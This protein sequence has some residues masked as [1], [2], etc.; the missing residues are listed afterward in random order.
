M[1]K[2]QIISILIFVLL[3]TISGYAGTQK[4]K[5]VSMPK[6][7]VEHTPRIVSAFA[8]INS[9]PQIVMTVP[10]G[11]KF[12]LTDIVSSNVDT[13][14][15]LEDEEIKT[16]VNL[17]HDSGYSIHFKSGIPFSSNS[18]IVIFINNTNRAITISGYLLKN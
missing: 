16:K 5:I 10:D 3:F 1:K 2:I 11:R 7:R 12:I 13:Y 6:V 14:D 9:E 4:M 17:N 8:I 15:I 18:D